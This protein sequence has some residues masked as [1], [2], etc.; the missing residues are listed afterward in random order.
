MIESKDQF[1]I[2][3]R[4]IVQIQNQTSLTM[5]SFP[6]FHDYNQKEISFEVYNLSNELK[7]NKGFQT[8]KF[9]LS[10]AYPNPFNNK[11]SIDFNLQKD[12][13]VELII[14]NSK[15]DKIKST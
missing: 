8:K 6:L 10:D 13:N 11:T 7:L 3:I 14:Y 1:E 9:T 5:T 15:N 2:N 12:G 4:P